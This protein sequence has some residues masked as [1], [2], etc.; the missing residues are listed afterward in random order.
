[1]F[2]AY[3]WSELRL[4]SEHNTF[5]FIF[6]S[7]GQAF[8]GDYSEYFGL[9]VDEDALVYLMLANHLVHTLYPDSV[10]IAEVKS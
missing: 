3:V 8:S 7:L 1:M 2:S 6:C 5:M 10:T 9:Q 4:P